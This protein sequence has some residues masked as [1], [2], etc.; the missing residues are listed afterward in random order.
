MLPFLYF[1][2]P[3]SLLALEFTPNNDLILPTIKPILVITYIS[4]IIIILQGVTR[5]G[6]TFV[7]I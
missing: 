5:N 3:K 6:V 1:C 7:E 2:Y 4:G